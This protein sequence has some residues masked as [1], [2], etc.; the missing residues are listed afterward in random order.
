MNDSDEVAKVPLEKIEILEGGVWKPLSEKYDLQANVH[1]V[2]FLPG[3][4]CVESQVTPRTSLLDYFFENEWRV[5]RDSKETK[6][7][8]DAGLWDLTP[9]GF[10][11]CW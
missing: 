1:V 9:E 11:V 4:F 5:Q 8:S 6:Q 10:Y 2:I 7:L 3:I